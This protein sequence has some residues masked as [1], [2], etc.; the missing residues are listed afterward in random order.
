MT[1]EQ[2]PA[3]QPGNRVEATKLHSWTVEEFDDFPLIVEPGDQGLVDEIS[4]E[5]KSVRTTWDK[6]EFPQ[7]KKSLSFGEALTLK[8]LEEE[9][10]EQKA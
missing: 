9:A 7:K 6:D 2:R 1:S 3:L 4:D 8:R 10:N 5:E